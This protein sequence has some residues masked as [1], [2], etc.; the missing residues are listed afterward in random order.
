MA[1]DGN[2]HFVPSLLVALGVVLC[3]HEYALRRID[4]LRHLYWSCVFVDEAHK[5]KNPK[6][7]L[8]IALKSFTCARSCFALTGTVIQNY[9]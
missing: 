3:S 5:L 4:N 9:N 7:Q 8:T 6:I 2:H 1:T